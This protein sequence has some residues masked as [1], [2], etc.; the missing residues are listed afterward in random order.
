MKTL[1]LMIAVSVGISVAHASPLN[2]K[3]IPVEASG[4]GHIDLDILRTTSFYGPARHIHVSPELTK[5]K[6]LFEQL[7][8]TCRG[9][10]FWVG[11]RRNP[12]AGSDGESRDGAVLFEFP[13]DGKL[14]REFVDK[15]IM[16]T[17][18]KKLSDDRYSAIIDDTTFEVALVDHVVA[19]SQVPESLTKTIAVVQGKAESLSG[20]V[21]SEGSRTRDMF[22][23]VALGKSLLKD[24]KTA[25]NSV[26][27]KSDV[28]S[29]VI[30]VGERGAE[31]W[32]KATAVIASSD[33]ALKVK[34]V[35]DGLVALASLS[36][37]FKSFQPIEKYFKVNVEGNTVVLSL[38]MP[39][40]MLLKIVPND[41]SPVDG[42]H[43]TK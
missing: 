31:V 39:S 34:S 38:L 22:V 3:R 29:L 21:L 37:D 13:S 27:L 26:L 8:A 19:V 4:V 12:R 18:T 14:A 32:A 5:F 10:S 30:N 11:D 23:F 17:H 15:L 41:A 42:P 40:A 43:K 28:T 16:L 6:P 25:A 20:R 24:I 9:V 35:I 33:G 1:A 7:F 36:D 2:P